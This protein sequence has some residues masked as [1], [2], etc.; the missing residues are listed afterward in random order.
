MRGSSMHIASIG[1]DLGT[2][3]HLVVLRDRN[4][5]MLRR[6][7][8]RSQL[9]ADTANLPASL[10]GLE[11]QIYRQMSDLSRDNHSRM[12]CRIATQSITLCRRLLVLCGCV[13][14]ICP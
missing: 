7:F 4:K 6:R 5:I 13:G 9:L 11:A 8:S 10:I 3:F 2:T 14:I 1:I 12:R